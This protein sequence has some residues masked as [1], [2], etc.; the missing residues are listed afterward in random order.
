MGRKYE[1]KFFLIRQMC[2]LPGV[3]QRIKKIAVSKTALQYP[4]TTS[5]SSVRF[6]PTRTT[7]N[8]ARISESFL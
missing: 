2:V 3:G 6:Y 8:V 4:I 5:N 1:L 7:N